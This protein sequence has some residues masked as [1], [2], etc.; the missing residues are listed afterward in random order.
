MANQ[1]NNQHRVVVG[2]IFTPSNIKPAAP[3]IVRGGLGLSLL[4]KPAVSQV[5]NTEPDI[6]KG[7]G[8]PSIA[9]PAVR[10]SAKEADKK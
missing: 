6:T 9:Q 3:R 7:V 8:T 5:K 4:A 1:N 10:P 2:E